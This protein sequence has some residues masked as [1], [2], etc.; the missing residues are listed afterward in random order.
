MNVPVRVQ[1]GLYG[2]SKKLRSVGLDVASI[3]ATSSWAGSYHVLSMGRHYDDYVMTGMLMSLPAIAGFPPAHP[4]ERLAGK[5]RAGGVTGNIGEAIAAIFARRYLSAGVDKIAHIKPRQPF[6]RRKS[7]DY[8][9]NIGILMPGPFKSILPPKFPKTWPEWWPVES[10]ARNN[11]KAS[12]DGRRD[13]LRQLFAYWDLLMAA[14]PQ[15]VGYGLIV[16]FKYQAER[17]VR[18]NIILPADQARLISE[19]KKG[20]EKDREAIVRGFLHGC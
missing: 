8:L 12:S 19:M 7:P 11:E 2:K 9:M 5:I 20:Y 14:Q 10:K 3:D 16:V 18:V 17:E 1:L 4:Y 15:L 13:A 6:K